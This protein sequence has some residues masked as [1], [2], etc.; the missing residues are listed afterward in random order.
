MLME[1]FA[2]TASLHR[3]PESEK[4]LARYAE[5]LHPLKPLTAGELDAVAMWTASSGYLDAAMIAA[6]HATMAPI[7]EPGDRPFSED[8]AAY[9]AFMH[10][11]VERAEQWA[12]RAIANDVVGEIHK[13]GLAPS[14][15]AWAKAK[16]G[17]RAGALALIASRPKQPQTDLAQVW[18]LIA[19]GRWRDARA[20]AEPALS[21]A[22]KQ[23]N[24]DHA[25]AYAFVGITRLETGDAPGA[26]TLLDE[27]LAAAGLC[28]YGKH[29]FVPDAQFALA[30]ALV[31]TGGDAKRARSLATAAR[32]GLRPDQ[33][34]ERKRIDDWLAAQPAH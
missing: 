25:E 20:H 19:L 5:S 34:A 29:Y 13:M 33:T 18:P 8:M 30:R 27:S 1:L 10:G 16:K 7:V 3:D 23:F 21:F 2:M 26:V 9:I 14:L 24:W 6:E 28:C 17:D 4:V 11:G 32:D 15:L 22:P 12:T 31:V